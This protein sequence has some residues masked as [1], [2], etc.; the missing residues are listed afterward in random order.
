MSTRKLPLRRGFV[1]VR[2][3]TDIPDEYAEAQL[4]K[5]LETATMDDLGNL[6]VTN[7]IVKEA[8]RK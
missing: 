6:R 1:E 2:F 3:F 7:V 5:R 8:R 4:K